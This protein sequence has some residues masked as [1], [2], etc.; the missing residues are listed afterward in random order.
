MGQNSFA[1][2]VIQLLLGWLQ[3][4]MSGIWS[5]FSGGSGGVMLKWLGDNWISILVVLLFAGVVLDLVIYL[6]RWRPFWWWFRKKRMVFDDA[7]FEDE[8]PSSTR[9]RKKAPPARRPSTIVPIRNN[10]QEEDLFLDDDLFTVK[11]DKLKK[12]QAKRSTQ[13]A[14]RTTSKQRKRPAETRRL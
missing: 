4:L 9:K 8:E 12:S 10:A 1:E 11:Q 6:V 14:V 13:A 2:N 7:L 5:L 3:S